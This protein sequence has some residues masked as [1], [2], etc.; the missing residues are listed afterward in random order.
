MHE[1]VP[2][3]TG[4][5]WMAADVKQQHE[6]RRDYIYVAMA[7]DEQQQHEHRRDYAAA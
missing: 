3:R 4:W 6:H 5:R 1:R 2:K 7:A